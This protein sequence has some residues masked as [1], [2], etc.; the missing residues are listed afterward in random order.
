MILPADKGRCV[1]IM[2]TKMYEDKAEELLS[3][4]S[5]Y[6]KLTKDPTPKYTTKLVNTLKKLKET[7]NITYAQYRHLYPTSHIPPK[8]Y[9]LPKIHK[10]FVPLRPIVASRGSITYNSARFLADILA[11]LVGRTPYFIK[12]SA[13]LVDKLSQFIIAPDE[14]LVSYDVTALFTSVPVQESIRVVNDLLVNDT[15]LVNRT[16]LTPT[17]ITELL[18]VCLN[19]TYFLYRGSFFQQVEG[20]AMGSP[21]SPIIAYLFMEHFE[22]KTLSTF[23]NPPRFWGRY[24]DDTMTIIKKDVIDRFTAHLNNTHPAIKFTFE[25]ENDNKIPMLDTTI[26]R[27]ADGTL[28][29]EV[30][31]KPTSTDQYLDFTSH[32]PLQHKLG[33]IRTLSHRANTIPS[34]EPAKTK[35]FTHMKRSLSICN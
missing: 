34:S 13:N 11:P 33:V 20:A 8:F 5:T 9:G 27:K 18:E 26:I 1:V 23:L 3:D 21:I 19:T 15:N 14:S 7:G 10:S 28:Q 16:Q 25:L 24:V 12:N 22:R 35:E 31:R 17:Q 30:Y 6:K 29:F 32:Q 2:P 4:T